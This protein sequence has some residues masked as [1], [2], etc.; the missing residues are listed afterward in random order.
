MQLIFRGAAVLFVL[1][2]IYHPDIICA[3]RM[4]SPGT[5]AYQDMGRSH[6]H[7]L[8]VRSAEYTRLLERA[9]MGLM[10][11]PNRA[12]YPTMLKT[13]ECYTYD[14]PHNMK[15]RCVLARVLLFGGRCECQPEDI[16]KHDMLM[17]IMRLA[18]ER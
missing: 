3:V 18:I 2:D 15:S 13:V 14:C 16:E 10:K 7:M 17:I 6:L 8:G 5:M 4:V 1:R 9:A 11:D 12:E